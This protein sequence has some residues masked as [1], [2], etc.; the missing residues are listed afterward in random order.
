MA[1]GRLL[2]MKFVTRNYVR[3]MRLEWV[4]VPS[5]KVVTAASLSEC[6]GLSG[7]VHARYG[8]YAWILGRTATNFWRSCRRDVTSA[9]IHVNIIDLFQYQYSVIRITNY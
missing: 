6:P 3:L 1:S 8:V 4:V 2:Q 9:L 5:Q 7:A